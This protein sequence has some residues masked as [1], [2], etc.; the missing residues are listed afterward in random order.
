[1][2]VVATNARLT[3]DQTLRLATMAHA[4]LARTIRPSHTPV[5]GD[6]V[7]ALSIGTHSVHDRDL[8]AVGALATRALERAVLRA[9]LRAERIAGIPSVADLVQGV[10]QAP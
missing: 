7:F 3:T 5:D 4:G 6:T 10:Q 8:V 2:A 9:I 1:L